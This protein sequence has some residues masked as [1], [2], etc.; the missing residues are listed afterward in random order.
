MFP[1]FTSR[2]NGDVWEAASDFRLADHLSVA[3]LP[4][5]GGKRQLEEYLSECMSTPFVLSRPLWRWTH[6]SIQASS[7]HHHDR[8]HHHHHHQEEEGGILLL[9]LL[10]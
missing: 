4:A 1:V 3:T 7:C 2:L 9:L 5:P 6:S 8:H 10:L